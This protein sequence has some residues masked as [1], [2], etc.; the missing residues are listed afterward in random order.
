MITAI[1]PK[2]AFKGTIKSVGNSR[3]EAFSYK[4]AGCSETPYY[5][6]FVN[7]EKNIEDLVSTMQPDDVVQVDYSRDI[8]SYIPGALSKQIGLSEKQ[9]RFVGLK[10]YER[11]YA[12]LVDRSESIRAN[13]IN[14]LKQNIEEMTNLLSK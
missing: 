7:I 10:S 1:S 3:S 9:L 14:F 2:V 11:D 12:E 8:M 13:V 5:T 4:D 6:K